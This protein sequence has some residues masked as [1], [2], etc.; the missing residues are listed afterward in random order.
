M[1]IKVLVENNTIIDKY[2]CGEPALSFYIEE[3]NAKILFDVGYSD[4]FLSNA[5]KLHININELSHI[6]VSHGHNDHT[7][8]FKYL[9]DSCDL[10]K[11]TIIAHP[12]TFKEKI[13]DGEN[14]SSPMSE[15]QLSNHCK[16]ILS[17]EPID[18]TQN[19]I[20]LG[21]IP[22]YFDFEQ[23]KVV[24]QQ[25][26]NGNFQDDLLTDDTAL[27]YKNENGIHIITGCSHSGICNIIEYA[28]KVCGDNRIAS[29][30]GGFH[31]LDI[32]PKLEKTIEYLKENNINELYPCHCV[33]FKARAE[34]NKFL[35]VIEV[36]VGMEITWR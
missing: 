36:G 31:L 19:L 21:E 11:T 15:E 23:R 28:K 13:Y 24:G 32:T 30:I 27:A 10:P 1:K 17:K 33:S 3:E 25:K 7:G 14:I 16:L 20:Y 9:F 5:D 29:V 4:L 12:Y 26:I 6:V 8:G 34:M 22:N 35:N 18:I 2:Y